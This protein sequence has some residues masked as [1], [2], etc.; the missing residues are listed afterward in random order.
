MGAPKRLSIDREQPCRLCG[1]RVRITLEADYDWPDEG[2]VRVRWHRC[3]KCWAS[4]PVKVEPAREA[5]ERMNP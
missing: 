5:G 1:G 3:L 4:A 2:V